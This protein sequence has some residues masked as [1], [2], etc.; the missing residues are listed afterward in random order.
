MTRPSCRGERAAGGLPGAPQHL[1]PALSAAS[2]RRRRPADPAR[3][4]RARPRHHPARPADVGESRGSEAR[5]MSQKGAPTRPPKP[6]QP[7]CEPR[8]ERLRP[9]VQRSSAS[10]QS[11]SGSG[12]STSATS[13]GRRNSSPPEDRVI[14]ARQRPRWAWPCGPCPRPWVHFSQPWQ[15]AAPGRACAQERFENAGLARVV[16]RRKVRAWK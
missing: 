8:L 3:R 11:Q 6:F 4:L 2:R 7:N 1:P 16:W 10:P 13:A 12:R 14:H 15:L 5:R 9:P